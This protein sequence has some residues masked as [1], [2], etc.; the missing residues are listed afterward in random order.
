[1]NVAD[2]LVSH[3]AGEKAENRE[4]LRIILNSICYLARQGLALWGCFKAAN[5]SDV[6]GELDSSFYQL[7]KTRT[8]DSPKLLKWMD[9]QRD[10][11]MTPDVY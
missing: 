10:K 1:M 9:K 11:F 7:L 6:P 4:M 2:M 5:N 3:L 8:K